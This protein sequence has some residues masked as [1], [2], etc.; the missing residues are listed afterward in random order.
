[1]VST[2]KVV[3]VM[4]IGTTIGL[5]LSQFVRSK[6]IYK[7]LHVTPVTEDGQPMLYVEG[8]IS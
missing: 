6:N 5:L 3:F 1:M 8:Y 7:M 4:L 2:I